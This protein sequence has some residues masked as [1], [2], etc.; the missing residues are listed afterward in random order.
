VDVYGDAYVAS[1]GTQQ[2]ARPNVVAGEPFYVYGSR[3]AIPGGR[4]INFNAFQNVT[5][6]MGDAPRNFLRG[7][8]ANEIDFA[9]RRQFDELA[10]WQA[11]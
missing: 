5:G 4:K 10:G 6:A 8:G 1:N 3:D 11:A 2:Y 7:F 9:M